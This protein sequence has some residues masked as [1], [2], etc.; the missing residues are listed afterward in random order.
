LKLYILIRVS[1]I[2]LEIFDFKTMASTHDQYDWVKRADGAYERSLDPIE[3][4]MVSW[5]NVVAPLKKKEV[6][7]YGL[8]KY[9]TEQA[10]VTELFRKA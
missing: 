4:M 5:G 10:N 7:F 6:M 3:R 2:R 9:K 1:D 8:I